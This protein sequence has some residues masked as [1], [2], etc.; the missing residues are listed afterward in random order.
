MKKSF[1]VISLFLCFLLGAVVFI[2][3]TSD[4]EGL[5]YEDNNTVRLLPL[6]EPIMIRVTPTYSNALQDVIL[7]R[8]SEVIAL[9]DLPMEHPIKKESIDKFN[10][11]PKA[12][13]LGGTLFLTNGWK[14]TFDPRGFVSVINSPDN[15]FYLQDIDDYPRY[16]G[17]TTM[18][19]KEI[20]NFARECLLKMGYTPEFTHSNRKPKVKMPGNLKNGGHVPFASVVWEN[21]QSKMPD[22]GDKELTMEE[23]E[24]LRLKRVKFIN[25]SYHVKI[26]INTQNKQLV[27][28]SFYPSRNQK[29]GSPVECDVQPETQSYAEYMKEFNERLRSILLEKSKKVEKTEKEQSHIYE[30]LKAQTNQVIQNREL[31]KRLKNSEEQ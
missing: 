16:L 2:I 12:G 1:I 8:I 27:G 28:L 7:P 21:D 30:I 9:L 17:K 31:N 11:C 15:W 5:V 14:F 4:D 13:E 3:A 29:I 23:F 6:D 10:I 19:K 25:A 24:D 22:E 20:I 26:E 18:S